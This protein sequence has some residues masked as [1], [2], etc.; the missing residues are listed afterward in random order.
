MA[1]T[2]TDRAF[3]IIARCREIAACTEVPGETTRLFLT[4]PMHAVHA[5]L[6]A[7]MEATGMNDPNYKYNPQPRLLTAEELARLKDL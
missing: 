1:G 5:L 7:W 3:R 4:P 2:Y 6:R